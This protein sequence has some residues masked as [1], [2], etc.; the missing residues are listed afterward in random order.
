MF[1]DCRTA[2]V[3]RRDAVAPGFCTPITRG[4][5]ITA[6]VGSVWVVFVARAAYVWC[7]LVA[8]L[9]PVNSILHSL[10]IVESGRHSSFNDIRLI[11]VLQRS[12]SSSVSRETAI[13]SVR[14]FE[15]GFGTEHFLEEHP[16]RV[17]FHR[18]ADSQYLHVYSKNRIL[19]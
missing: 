16:R 5:L 12:T 15:I 8:D 9:R 17:V 14:R 3:A 19:Q 7:G 13:K 18:S 1:F 11:E 10:V 4:H 6:W 2:A